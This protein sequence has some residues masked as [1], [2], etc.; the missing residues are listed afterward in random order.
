MKK[1]LM[2]GGARCCPTLTINKKS[3]GLK[4]DFGGK[5]KLTKDQAKLLYKELGG[6][7]NESN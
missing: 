6:L 4:D 1:V 3:I 2:C 7:F 5:V